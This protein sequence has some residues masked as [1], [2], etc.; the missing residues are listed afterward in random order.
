MGDKLK[1]FC[2]TVVFLLLLALIL[3]PVQRVMARK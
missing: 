3:V 1:F 2:K